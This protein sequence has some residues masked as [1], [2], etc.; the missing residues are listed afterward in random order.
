MPK[1][2]PA[3]GLARRLDRVGVRQRGE[4]RKLHIKVLGPVRIN[5]AICG[6]A[7][8]L[9]NVGMNMQ[10]EKSEVLA[11]IQY[12]G[13]PGISK[14]CQDAVV[15]LLQFG[16]RITQARV[17]SCSS[18][19]CFLL[20]VNVGGLIAIKSGFGSGYRG[21]GSHAFSYVLKLLDAYGV[22]IEEYKVEHDV[23]ERLDNSA[24]TMLDIDMLNSA[25]PV[26]PARWHDYILKEYWELKEKGML[27]KEFHPVIPLAIIDGRITDLALSF[28]DGP[29]EKLLTG[30]RR[31]E[32]I[33]RK[34]T[35]IDE[36]GTKL[37]SQAFIGDKARLGWKNLDGGERTGR[38]S[39]FTS[40][41]MAYRNPRSHR[42]LNDDGHRQLAEFMLLNQLY[43]LEK[44]ACEDWVGSEAETQKGCRNH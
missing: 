23:I 30:Y 15:R 42:E 21:E 43:L 3:V 11:G 44:E 7:T 2:Q 13:E 24:L 25:R 28:W 41:Y 20:A 6:F 19:H 34:R 38:G 16:D 1:L 10:L 14:E 8:N 26:R 31:L 4:L 37:F 36:Y 9:Q 33:V 27:W 29:D 39:L 40:T 18:E 5:F 17:L 12:A 35:R 32:D 22:P